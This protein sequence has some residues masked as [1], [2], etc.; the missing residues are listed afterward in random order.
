MNGEYWGYFGIDGLSSVV[1]GLR[2]VEIEMDMVVVEMPLLL[3]LDESSCC[4]SSILLCLK[5]KTDM[6]SRT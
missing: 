1:H 3:P 4:S 2:R 5:L 6:N